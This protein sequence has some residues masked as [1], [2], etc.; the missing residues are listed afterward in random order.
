MFKA[1]IV[2]KNE[3][4]KTSASVEEISEDR[5]PEGEVTVDV[6]SSTVT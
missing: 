5:L 4:G 2:E 3:D 1:L 6:E